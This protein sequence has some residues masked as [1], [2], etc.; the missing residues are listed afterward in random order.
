MTNVNVRAFSPG[1]NYGTS[2]RL[3]HC[4]RQRYNSAKKEGDQTTPDSY[5]EA[6]Y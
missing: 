2:G 3:N 1:Y 6:G 5:E 4:R